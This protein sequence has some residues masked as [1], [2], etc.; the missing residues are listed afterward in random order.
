MDKAL[1]DLVKEEE[2]ISKTDII[3]NFLNAVGMAIIS[4][5]LTLLFASAAFIIHG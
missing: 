4:I 5:G 3:V 1:W 2:K